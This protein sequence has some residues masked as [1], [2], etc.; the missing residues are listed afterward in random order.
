MLRT[1]IFLG[2]GASKAEGAPLQGELFE[3]IFANRAKR[4]KKV[5]HH[6]LARF[7]RDM[8]SIDTKSKDISNILFPTF[9]EVLGLT[10]LAMLRKQGFKGFELETFG[11]DGSPLRNIS[12]D[13]IL[14]MAE[15]LGSSVGAKVK[16]HRQLVRELDKSRTLGQTAFISTNYDILIDNA[17]TSAFKRWDLDYAV[18][19]R[20][21][22]RSGDWSRPRPDRRVL[23]LKPHGSLNW[24]HCPVCNELELTPR[25]KGALRLISKSNLRRCVVCASSYVPVIVPPTFYKDLNNIVVAGVL[26]R[27]EQV[28]REVEQVVFCGYSFPEA[29]MHI[30]YILKRAQINRASTVKARY[31][32]VN[33]FAGKSSETADEERRRFGRFLGRNVV[34][35][36]MSFEEFATH[37]IL[38]AKGRGRSG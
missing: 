37:P 24:L 19:F 8:F 10:D 7:F 23:L 13:L 38:D 2:A 22:D 25:A 36:K 16:W 35:T 18:D 14:S 15:I 5:V 12:R 6:E 9:E 11:S 28:L 27:T 1:A 4:S 21:F 26:H 17:L 3:R 32:L 29:D 31:F 33:N 20:N 34:D 30:K